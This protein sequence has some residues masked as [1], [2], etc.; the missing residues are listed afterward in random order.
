MDGWIIG[1]EMGIEIYSL[2]LSELKVEDIEIEQESYLL[3]T[4]KQ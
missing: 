3:A 2:L 4:Q 1:P